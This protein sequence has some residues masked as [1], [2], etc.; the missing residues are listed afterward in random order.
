MDWSVHELNVASDDVTIFLRD[1]QPRE[2]TPF[3]TLLWIHGLGEHGGRYVHVAEELVQAGWRV[4]ILDLR[5]HGQS[6][7]ARTHVRTFEDY[8][9]DVSRIWAKLDLGNDRTVLGAHSMGGLIAIRSVQMGVTHPSALVLASPLLRVKVRVSPLKRMLGQV[10]VRMLPE[11]RFRNGLDSKNMTRD[12]EFARK[13]REDPLMNRTVTA[14]WF[15]A[16]ESALVE[17]HRDAARIAIP[18]LAIRGLSDATIDGEVLSTW[19][20]RTS[21]NVKE[22]ISLPDHVHELLHESDWRE[23]LAT[24]IQWLER[25]VISGV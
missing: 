15:F 3:R 2:L 19:L 18:V 1:Y 14:S 13:R 8:V 24:I 10:L 4:L 20:T 12:A 23:T 21:S 22:L 25:I 11:A 17:A 7:G 9:T 5:G 16:M 6:S